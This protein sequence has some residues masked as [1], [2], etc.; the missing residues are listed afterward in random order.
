MEGTLLKLPARVGTGETVDVKIFAKV[1]SVKK[2]LTLTLKQNDRVSSIKKQI[3][4]KEGIAVKEQTVV[5]S[6]QRLDD[7]RTLADYNICNDS[8]VYV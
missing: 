5:F 1:Q 6:G 4:G 7:S 2:T 8:L 3:K